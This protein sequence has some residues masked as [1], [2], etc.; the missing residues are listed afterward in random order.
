MSKKQKT[1]IN[2]IRVLEIF[3]DEPIEDSYKPAT[4]FNIKKFIY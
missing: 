3:I 1:S 4:S 2:I